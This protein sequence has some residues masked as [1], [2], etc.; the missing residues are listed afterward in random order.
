MKPWQVFNC[1]GS[2][3][4]HIYVQEQM[5]KCC[6]PTHSSAILID[7]GQVFLYWWKDAVAASNDPVTVPV[8]Q[9]FCKNDHAEFHQR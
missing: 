4:L 5:G 6:N 8:C 1:I 7:S 3:C 2:G 9:N